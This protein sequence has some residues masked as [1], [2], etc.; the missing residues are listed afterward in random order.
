MGPSTVSSKWNT[1]GN[2]LGGVI[3]VKITGVCSAWDCIGF[4]WTREYSKQRATKLFQIEDISHIDQTMETRNFRAWNENSG[5]R[6]AVT[7]SQQW[8]KASVERKL[9]ECSQWKAI[10]QCSK[11]DSCSF[12][13]D[14]VSGNRRDQK[15]EGQSSSPTP[16][17]KRQT[18]GK[19]PSKGSELRGA[20][21]SGKGGRIACRNFFRRKGTNPSCNYW[22]PPVCLNYKS[23]SGWICWK[24]PISTRWGWWTAQ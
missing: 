2:G 22:H 10:G 6:G 21:P 18:D 16:K 14:S 17:A 24:M 3:Q 20:R 9:G 4:V 23:E 19:K 13:H 15:Q 8:R 7:K 5:K 11:G 12:S 1:Y